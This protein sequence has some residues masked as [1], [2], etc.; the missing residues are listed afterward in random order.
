MEFSRLPVRRVER[1]S[2]AVLPGEE[3]D[4]PEPAAGDRPPTPGWPLTVPAVVQLLEDGLDLADCTILDCNSQLN[5]TKASAD[6]S[7]TPK[8]DTVYSILRGKDLEGGR[9]S[10]S[11]RGRV[12]T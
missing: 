9:F 3:P 7:L 1:A 2:Y 11:L 12:W 10:A 4:A 8:L 5:S 6:A